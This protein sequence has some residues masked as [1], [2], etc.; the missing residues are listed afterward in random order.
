MLRVELYLPREV[1]EILTLPPHPQPVPHNLNWKQ[2]L[3]S[4]CSLEILTT[5]EGTNTNA[6]R[7]TESS[8]RPCGGTQ[9]GGH[10][11]GGSDKV[12]IGT[13]YLGTLDTVSN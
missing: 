1:T 11:Q 8:R 7:H 13:V 9:R 6:D 2:D 5:W 3:S 4:Q 12:V 10:L